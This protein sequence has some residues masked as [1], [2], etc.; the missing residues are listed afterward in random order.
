[1]FDLHLELLGYV[2]SLAEVLEKPCVS[3]EWK[4][5]TGL[6]Y[7]LGRL[8]V[9]PSDTVNGFW[10]IFTGIFRDLPGFAG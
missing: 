7:A 4:S 8:L 3:M 2:N 10:C 5:L 6:P 1:M 9:C